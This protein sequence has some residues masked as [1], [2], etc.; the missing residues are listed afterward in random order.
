M[1]DQ[2]IKDQVKTLIDDIDK[3]ATSQTGNRELGNLK[4]IQSRL[5]EIF[6]LKK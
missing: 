1:L 6:N 4:L 5:T 2:T 3:M